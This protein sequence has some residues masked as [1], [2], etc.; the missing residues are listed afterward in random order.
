MS[1]DPEIEVLRRYSDRATPGPLFVSGV[2]IL[3]LVAVAIAGLQ[4]YA[5]GYG[6]LGMSRE[7]AL[8][9][10]LG[11]AFGIAALL[12]VIRLAGGFP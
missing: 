5:V 7:E 10:G 12:V 6:Y 11:C 8:D 3:P 9:R 2:R 4:G 1:D